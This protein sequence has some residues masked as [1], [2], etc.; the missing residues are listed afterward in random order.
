LRECLSSC[1]SKLQNSI[2][3][4]TTFLVVGEDLK[5]KKTKATE[6]VI[7]QAAVR[8]NVTILSKEEFIDILNSYSMAAERNEEEKVE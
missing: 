8:H 4:T 1:G 7:Y 5:G 2:T 3:R 6:T